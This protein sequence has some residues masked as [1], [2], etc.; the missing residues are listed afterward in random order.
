MLQNIAQYFI[1]PVI[2][3]SVGLL[4]A[5]QSE[6]EK[7]RFTL[8]GLIV[9]FLLGAIVGGSLYAIASHLFWVCDSTNCGWGW[10]EF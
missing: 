10:V 7:L 4:I 8:R 1:F 3:G 5:F 9:A 6:D 2:G